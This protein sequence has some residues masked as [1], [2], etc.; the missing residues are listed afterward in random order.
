MGEEP[1]ADE[2]RQLRYFIES[3]DNISN[4]LFAFGHD[5]ELKA[6]ET[7]KV[8]VHLPSEAFGLFDTDGKFVTPKGKAVVFVGGQQPDARSEELL[9]RK[10]TAL[11]IEL[12]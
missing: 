6:G 7:K 12:P 4:I 11:E 8:S 1:T 5:A 9:G 3:K 2:L 10:V